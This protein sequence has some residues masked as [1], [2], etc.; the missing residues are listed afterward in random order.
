ME[1]VLVA[2]IKVL[3]PS[4]ISETPWDGNTGDYIDI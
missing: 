4:P 2:L 3:F 1:Q